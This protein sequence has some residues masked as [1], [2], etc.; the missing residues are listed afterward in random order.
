MSDRGSPS[1]SATTV[2]PTALS[3]A[4]ALL[5]SCS[6]LEALQRELRRAGMLPRLLTA[7]WTRHLDNKDAPTVVNM[8]SPVPCLVALQVS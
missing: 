1:D 8:R 3:L 2:K 4:S 6:Q 7:R 5:P